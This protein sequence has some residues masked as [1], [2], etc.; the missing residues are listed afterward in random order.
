[1]FKFFRLMTICSIACFLAIDGFACSEFKV[2]PDVE[3]TQIGAET[4]RVFVELPRGENG[5]I[6][7]TTRATVSQKFGIEISYAPVADRFCVVLTDVDAE[8]GYSEFLIELDQDLESGT[9]EYD[10]VAAHE[11]EHM[12]AYA[13]VL[14]N[15]WA[16]LTDAIRA[17]A[18]AVA[19]ISV[20]SDTDIESAADEMQKQ[21]ANDTEFQ[22]V[23]QKI[24]AEQ[25]IENRRIDTRGD[26]LKINKCP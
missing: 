3:I 13:K 25:E 11:D 21:I 9:C 1:M 2:R 24:A 16:A 6:H 17:A 20:A 14:R 7:G 18:D 19:P 10:I 23:M 15:N 8:I 4:K 22:L 26:A 12:S 5:M